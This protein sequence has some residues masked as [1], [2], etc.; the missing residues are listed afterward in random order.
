MPYRMKKFICLLSFIVLMKNGMAQPTSNDIPNYETKKVTLTSGLEGSLLQFAKLTSGSVSYKT[1]PRYSYFFNTGVD[2]NFHLLKNL[3]PYTGFQ[4]KNIGLITQ[5]NDSI[6]YKERVYTIGAPLGIKLFSNDRKFMFK[7]GGDIAL[8]FNYKLKHFLNDKKI[9]KKNEFFSNNASLM[10][11]SVFAGFSYSGLTLC[12][13]YYL[14]NFYNPSFNKG[15]ARL[16]TISLGIHLDENTLK[17]K[18]KQDDS[19]KP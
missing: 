6:K 9:Y 18:K 4:I 8:A 1:I 12:G 15:V 14:T 17:M 3:A 13:N 19:K 7:A 10:F 16:I 5:I 2:I 11:A